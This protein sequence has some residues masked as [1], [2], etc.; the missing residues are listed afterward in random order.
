MKNKKLLSLILALAMAFSLAVPAFAT[1]TATV[2]NT[3]L[4][5]MSKIDTATT[6]VNGIYQAPVLALTVPKKINLLLNPYG[7]STTINKDT[8][9]EERDVQR[10]IVSADNLIISRSNVPIQIKATATGTI[11]SGSGEGNAWTLSKTALAA[12]SEKKE[13]L[14]Y[15]VFGD[16]DTSAITPKAN[17]DKFMV[18]TY[19]A[20]SGSDPAKIP[21]EGITIDDIKYATVAANLENVTFADAAAAKDGIVIQAGE[22]KETKITKELSECSVSGS[23]TDA[24]PYVYDTVSAVAFKLD[25]AMV[26][27]PKAGSWGKDDKL[28][29][30]VAW[31]FVPNTQAV[32]LKATEYVAA[33]SAPGNVTV[34]LANLVTDEAATPLFDLKNNGGATNTTLTQAGVLTITQA[35]LLAKKGASATSVA[36]GDKLSFKV[37]FSYMNNATTSEEVTKSVVLTVRVVDAVV[38][39]AYTV[40]G[41]G[42]TQLAAQA[43]VTTGGAASGAP[44]G[45]TVASDGKIDVTKA[46]LDA[47][48]GGTALA[49]GDVVY[50][51]PFTYKGSTGSADV[52]QLMVIKVTAAST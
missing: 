20:A 23:G 36:T 26:G 41:A 35:D 17:V 47:I 8:A 29:V 48:N 21:Y 18:D 49:A 52:S 14:V 6:T 2:D 46:C 7:V 27:N 34:N 33:G 16:V 44:A 40:G 32:P 51:G 10:Q 13:A 9:L 24:D 1:A 37:K 31:K 45:V 28:T 3:N 39:G 50:V 25:G 22:G 19:V 5:D 15:M 30:S 4:N 11:A 42:I 38:A 43:G 12:N